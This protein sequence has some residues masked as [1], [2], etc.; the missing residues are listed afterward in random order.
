MFFS[1][2]VWWHVS[3]TAA[4]VLICMVAL[5]VG[6]LD[7]IT[8]RQCGLTHSLG[9]RKYYTKHA[10]QMK[11]HLAKVHWFKVRFIHAVHGIAAMAVSRKTMAMFVEVS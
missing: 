11:M 3:T 10:D 1:H 6:L 4:F 5:N 7:H 9:N 8:Y 2:I